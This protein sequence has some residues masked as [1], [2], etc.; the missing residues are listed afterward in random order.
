MA[1]IKTE[2]LVSTG[3]VDKDSVGYRILGE[4]PVVETVVAKTVIGQL[5]RCV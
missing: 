5:H 4:L 1:N 3:N 2:L